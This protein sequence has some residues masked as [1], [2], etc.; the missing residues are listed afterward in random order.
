MTEQKNVIGG[1]VTSW[2]I[3]LAVPSAVI[4]GIGLKVTDEV[5]WSLGERD[6]K[7]IAILQKAEEEAKRDAENV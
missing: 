2:G 7:P 5:M 6:G 1:K 3:R 4:K